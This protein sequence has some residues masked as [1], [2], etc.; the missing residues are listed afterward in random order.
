MGHLLELKGDRGGCLALEILRREFPE[1]AD[2]WD[3]N[4]LMC[5]VT[6]LVGGFRGTFDAM[7]RVPELARLRDGVRSSLDRLDGSFA[8]E[9][10]EDQLKITGRGDGVGHFASSAS[11]RML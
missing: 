2:Y 6:I 4:W 7:F 5:K 9:S 10:M 1:V 3:G 11:R 8:F